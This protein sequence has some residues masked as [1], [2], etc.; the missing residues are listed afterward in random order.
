M[1][2][3]ARKNT[4]NLPPLLAQEAQRDH[5]RIVQQ[6]KR[7]TLTGMA[8]SDRSVV[9]G[10]NAEILTAHRPIPKNAVNQALADEGY[11]DDLNG[12]TGIERSLERRS[13]PPVG[14]R[15]RETQIR[16]LMQKNATIVQKGGKGLWD[17][18]SSAFY[19]DYLTRIAQ[20]VR[21]RDQGRI[22]DIAEMLWAPPAQVRAFNPHMTV[23]VEEPNGCRI[24][25]VASGFVGLVRMKNDA[26]D[27]A[28]V[29]LDADEFA[30]IFDPLARVYVGEGKHR[31]TLYGPTF[32]ATRSLLGKTWGKLADTIEL[33]D[34][35]RTRS[36]MLPAQYGV[37]YDRMVDT[38]RVARASKAYAP[39]GTIDPNKSMILVQYAFEKA[40]PYYWSPDMCSLLRYTAPAMPEYTV[41][42][43][44]FPTLAGFVYFA[45]PIE[46]PMANEHLAS[47]IWYTS[48]D[49]N[50]IA[51]TFFVNTPE[52]PTGICMAT[53]YLYFD[54]SLSEALQNFQED[55]EAID[56]AKLGKREAETWRE[57]VK[58]CLRCFAASLS[59][60]SQ[61]ITAHHRQRGDRA[62]EKRYQ[63]VT[64]REPELVRVI[65][66]RKKQYDRR[67]SDAADA[68]AVDWSCQWLV[69][70]PH[71][72]W[73]HQFYPGTNE[74]KWVLIAPY[75][76]GPTDRPFKA[77]PTAGQLWAITQ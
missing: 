41:R 52:Y 48:N 16:Q 21:G 64:K 5:S 24:A 13:L 61:R 40:D 74:H 3:K 11:M 71:G 65:T 69:G 29:V 1:A 18:P 51:V 25:V 7:K 19:N 9:S 76:K 43:Q 37:V 67:P 36:G 31:V 77:L 49:A 59:I 42:R 35:W 32:S 10:D 39:P 62:Q 54:R 6:R 66:L 44:D 47:L 28:V 33:T 60:M 50:R 14:T 68:G 75:R 20:F 23:T 57:N 27:L 63:A 58:A 72:F 12:L 55:T 70:Y 17:D 2:K 22:S 46:L 15:A 56:L 34:P 30:I 45:K 8:V 4:H 26:K 38:A 53:A 73:R